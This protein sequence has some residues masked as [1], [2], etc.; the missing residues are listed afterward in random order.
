M[1]TEAEEIAGAGYPNELRDL[2]MEQG[3]LTT[4][5]KKTAT[6]GKTER[7]QFITL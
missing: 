6:R 3:L 2:F 4:V 5:S 1:L 7:S